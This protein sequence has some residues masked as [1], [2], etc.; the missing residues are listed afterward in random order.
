[1]KIHLVE[2]ELSHADRRTDGNMSK[3]IVDFRN[4]VN[5]PKKNACVVTW[6]IQALVA[7][8]DTVTY[9]TGET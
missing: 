1:M 2:A 7:L 4:F 5:A 6:D 8:L 9:I 3:L